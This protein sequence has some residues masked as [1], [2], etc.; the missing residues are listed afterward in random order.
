[1]SL[2]EHHPFLMTFFGPGNALAWS[3]IHN[4]NLALEQFN[5]FAPWLETVIEDLHPVV[6]PR[7]KDKRVFWYGLAK[8]DQQLGELREM[9]QAHIGVSFADFD[10]IRAELNPA[11]LIEAAIIDHYGGRAFRFSTWLPHSKAQIDQIFAILLQLRA[12]L[13]H[14]PPVI[15]NPIRPQGRILRDIT[16]ALHRQDPVQAKAYLAELKQGGGVGYQNELFIELRC[17]AAG[18]DWQGIM[19]HPDLLQILDLPRPAILTDALLLA[20]YSQFLLSFE[21]CDDLSG[22][23]YQFTEVV[24]KRMPGLFKGPQKAR[25]GAS[26]KMWL[27][28][29]LTEQSP[30]FN[31]A[32]RLIADQ[33]KNSE[34]DSKWFDR[35]MAMFPQQ[36]KLVVDCGDVVGN[37]AESTQLRLLQRAKEDPQ[38]VLAH[39][40]ELPVDLNVAALALEC[41]WSLDT[42]EAAQQCHDLLDALGKVHK[43]E[44][45]SNRFCRKYYQVVEK[46]LPTPA[47]EISSWNDWLTQVLKNPT[48]TLAS[49]FAEEG[50]RD[51]SSDALDINDFCQQISQIK[52]DNAFEAGQQ[53]R[54]VIPFLLGWS[55]HQDPAREMGELW[56]MLL[57]QLSLD[58][59]HSKED[60]FLVYDLCR[61]YLGGTITSAGYRELLALI[62]LVME[63]IGADNVSQRLDLLELLVVSTSPAKELVQCLINIS[64]ANFCTNPKRYQLDEWQLLLTLASEV[65]LS[66]PLP[67]TLEL[68]ES[69]DS[70][71]PEFDLNGKRIGIYT[72]TESVGQRVKKQLEALFPKINVQLNHDKVA[73]E[74]LMALAENVDLFVF[75]WRSSAHQAFYSIKA[76]RRQK[77]KPF[78]LPQGKGSTSMMRCIL[79]YKD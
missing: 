3:K 34:E 52:T 59:Q 48:W 51:W 62:E 72:L 60:L 74:S 39:L 36:T 79:E 70:T 75:A 11:D 64:Y 49:L 7:V 44:L 73:T 1:M 42:Q 30:D 12:Q 26:A 53:L 28:W 76:A 19:D 15:A 58:E 23:Q 57:E 41:A 9:L 24:A 5:K 25:S 35:L 17:L 32:K 4:Q 50:A 71:R 66:L 45:L 21:V 27:L 18:N 14:R 2:P 54:M 69:T 68:G 67:E 13:L 31:K 63:C 43:D 20:V 6:L 16:T 61:E 77:S 29:L 55:S 38:E 33:K 8:S 65:G 10:G 56:L 78:L 46:L 47:Q 40:L 22:Q 37:S